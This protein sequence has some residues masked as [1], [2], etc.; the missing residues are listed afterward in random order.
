VKFGYRDYDPSVSRWTARDPILF[1]GGQGNLYMYVGNES[2]LREDPRGLQTVV[3]ISRNKYGFD[4]RAAAV[5]AVLKECGISPTV[6]PGNI[7][8][9]QKKLG[10]KCSKKCYVCLVCS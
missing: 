6:F 8:S 3:L 10:G 2:L 5:S 1:E 9:Q 4:D 7:A